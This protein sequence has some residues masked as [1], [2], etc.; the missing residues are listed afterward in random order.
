MDRALRVAF[1]DVHALDAEA[2]RERRPFLARF[3]LGRAVVEIMGEIDQRALDEPG[4]HAGV[5]AAAGDGR[6]AAGIGPPFSEHAF[7]QRIVGARLVAEIR[8]EVKARPRLDDRIDIER[9]DFAHETHDVERR[10]ID[11]DIDA[12]PLA[13]AFGEQRCEDF[14][15]IVA[16]QTRLDESD[17]AFL[18]KLP[19]SVA[20]I[21][22]DEALAVEVE[23]PLDQGQDSLADRPE[24]DHHDGA[25]DLRVNGPGGH[26][27]SPNGGR[28]ACAKFMTAR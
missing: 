11:G 9:A 13:A 23:M 28:A 12:E 26:I 15:V 8:V 1:G 19:I 25:G 6:H 2:L 18:R 21:D 16:R 5:G 20:G 14:L 4:D 3:R 22:D 7:A 17:T 10:R 27:C 24:A